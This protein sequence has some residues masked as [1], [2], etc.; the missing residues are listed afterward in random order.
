M[1]DIFYSTSLLH[2]QIIITFLALPPYAHR[3][4]IDECEN[5]SS[6]SYYDY[7]ESY[8]HPKDEDGGKKH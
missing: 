6:A 8:I 3:C 7:K 2:Y 1:F 4:V 5:A